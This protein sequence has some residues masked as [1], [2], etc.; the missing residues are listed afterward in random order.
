MSRLMPSVVA[1]QLQKKLHQPLSKDDD[2]RFNSVYKI[3]MD[4]LRDYHHNDG[5]WGWW[6]DDTSNPYLTALVLDGMRLL[7][8][9]GYDPGDDLIKGGIT[10]M[11]KREEQLYEQLIDPKLV[12]DDYWYVWN[13]R[14]SKT[15]LVRMLYTLSF[16]KV[17]I[18]G[19][20]QRWLLNDRKH[21]T[22]ESLT[23]LT[24]AFHNLKDDATA[25]LFYDRLIELANVTDEF[26]DWQHNNK[27]YKKLALADM[28]DYSYRFTGVETTALALKAVLAMEPN[29]FNRI[30]AIKRWILLQRGRDGWDNTKTTAEV[31]LALMQDELQSRA[32]HAPGNFTARVAFD[33]KL[34]AN[35]MSNQD[36][37]YE[38]QKDVTVPIPQTRGTL[39]IEK[40]GPG[41]LYY[42]ALIT[43]FRNLKAGD[44]I[45]DKGMPQGLRLTR[46]F[47][48]LVPGPVTS[49]GSI[50]FKSQ[51]IADGQIKAGETVLM[52]TYVE[53]PISLPYI[54]VQALLPSGAEVVAQDDRESNTESDNTPGI[55]GD[56]GN[57]WWNHQ[58][59]LDDRIVYFGTQLPQGKS[60]FHTMIRMELPGNIQV[61]P[62][63]LEGMYT[64][65][66]HA[67][68]ALDSLHVN[69]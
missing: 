18:P 10:W 36:N 62:V 49:D 38:S 57:V 46:K 40:S 54:M 25:K 11:Q 41:R 23:Y 27:M 8:E 60:E 50:H 28:S 31:F 22:P 32:Q 43:Y 37:L 21:L 53:S 7:K 52:K 55:E 45:A 4:K 9:V 68:S 42:N 66:V 15:D 61:G 64:N 44:Q 59:I 47:F 58:D 30:E 33:H 19:D 65:S 5:G 1:K 63:T 34:L 69:D 17:P 51:Q 14:E 39:S 16:N 48:R 2:E 6:R 20:Q 24:L 26:T 12:K 13:V 29:N 3:A 67:Y 35:F 56:W